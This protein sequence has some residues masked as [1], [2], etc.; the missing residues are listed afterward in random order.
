MRAIE[1]LLW[2]LTVHVILKLTT[3]I[4]TLGSPC[5]L[6]FQNVASYLSTTLLPNGC[7]IKILKEVFC[8]SLYVCFPCHIRSRDFRVVWPYNSSILLSLLCHRLKFLQIM[9]T[10]TMTVNTIILESVLRFQE[11][12][13]FYFIYFLTYSCYPSSILKRIIS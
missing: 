6:K 13:S 10:I 7:H 8:Y 4:A 1:E 2:H 11:Q 5:C 12:V 9:I 3:S